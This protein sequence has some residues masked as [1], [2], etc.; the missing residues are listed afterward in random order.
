[1]NDVQVLEFAAPLDGQC[2]AKSKQSGTR[3]KKSAEPGQRVC[4]M[5]GGASPQ[6][7]RAALS[8]LKEARDAA[9]DELTKAITEH[10]DK[11]DPKT[12]LD[13]TVKLTDKVELLEGRATARQESIRVDSDEVKSMLRER[14]DQLT[15]S[16]SRRPDVLEMVKDMA[17]APKRRL[18]HS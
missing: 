14:L 1:M 15:R 10:G 5:H 11:F 18:H 4:R 12:L 7:Q 8:R 3:C 2:N 9:L 16:Q 17:D 6:A 13:I